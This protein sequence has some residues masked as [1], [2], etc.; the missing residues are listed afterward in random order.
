[1]AI[2]NVTRAPTHDQKRH[3][4]EVPEM[5]RLPDIFEICRDLEKNL[6]RNSTSY[7]LL[8]N[9]QVNFPKS[10]LL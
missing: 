1:M 3:D 7:W 6:F 4:F 2:E 9:L 5:P 10:L 8:A